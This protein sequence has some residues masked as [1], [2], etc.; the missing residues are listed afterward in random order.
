MAFP[1]RSTRSCPTRAPGFPH[2]RDGGGSGVADPDLGLLRDGGRGER[3]DREKGSEKRAAHRWRGPYGGRR[4]ALVVLGTQRFGA[5]GTRPR[6]CNGSFSGP[7]PTTATAA[8]GAAAGKPSGEVGFLRELEPARL[9]RETRARERPRHGTLRGVGRR[10]LRRAAL[11]LVGTEDLLLGL[12]VEQ[13]LELRA[14]DRLALE[15]QPADAL[16]LA[17]VRLER[18]L[19][20]LV[21]G[22]HDAADL[23]VDL[24]GDLVGVVGLRGELAAEE[25]LA[26][27][28]AEHARAELLAHAEAHHHLLG[29]GRDLLEVVGG[30]RGDLGEDDLLGGAAAK[31]H[32]HRVV[33]LGLRGEELVLGRQRDRVPERLAAGDVPAVDVKVV[34]EE[35]N[36]IFPSCKID[37]RP[38]FRYE[39]KMIEQAKIADIK[40]PFEKQ[41]ESKIKTRQQDK[42][43]ISLYDGFVLQKM[44]AEMI[45]T[46]EISLAHI[47]I[48]FTSLL[49]CTFSE[50]DWRYHGRAVICGT[51]SI[52]S[53]TGI[54]EALAKPREF[55]LAQLGGMAAADNDSLK[56]KFAGRFIDYDD[57]DKIT[58]ASINYVL[59]AI[60]FF[61]TGWRAFLQ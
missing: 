55:Y 39:Q 57:E 1:S 35:I 23:V 50:D 21:R 41:P 7:S 25:R 46:A 17:A 11:G 43:M 59:Q 44:F 56:K 20:R 14:L 49:T 61:I 48:I 6:F 33:E 18:V 4:A 30:A 27:V 9:G 34:A 32:R 10:K 13:R 3:E 51:P 58:A 40:Q 42:W 47:H 31:G 5:P 60:F 29:R 45:P 19:G 22:L 8:R 36:K 38:P 16:E 28:V 15:Q 37:I 24:A 52:I 2:R 53:T 12:A 26:V 54:V